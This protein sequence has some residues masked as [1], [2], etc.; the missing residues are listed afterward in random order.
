MYTSLN[1]HLFHLRSIPG[2][3][4][5]K[6]AADLLSNALVGGGVGFDENHV[7]LSL[8]PS[9]AINLERCA[10]NQTGTI[11]AKPNDPERA[12][13]VRNSGRW[14]DR[15]TFASIKDGTIVSKSQSL[16]IALWRIGG[17]AV[18][19]EVIRTTKVI[20]DLIDAAYSYERLSHSLRRIYEVHFCCSSKLFEQVGKML[21]TPKDYVRDLGRAAALNDSA[22]YLEGYDVLVTLLRSKVALFTI[23]CFH[24][25]F[26]FL[27]IDFAHP[28]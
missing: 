16:D 8:S 15:E 1:V 4:E 20:M 22:I 14:N 27:G 25:V 3:K 21:K 11:V 7:I 6:E 26:N 24:V 10:S 19:L 18:A 13:L 28:E 5:A 9:G 17:P 23:E 2:S 12:R